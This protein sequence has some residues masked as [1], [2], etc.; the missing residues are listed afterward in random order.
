MVRALASQAEAERDKRARII[1]ADGEKLSSEKLRQAADILSSSPASLQIRTLQTIQT[2]ST[3]HNNTI[4][5][6]IPIDL[7]IGF[8]KKHN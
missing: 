3:E 8:M 4:V 2:I 1:A 6:P 7:V 5:V